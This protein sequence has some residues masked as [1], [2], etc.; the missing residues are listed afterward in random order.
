MQILAV[1]VRYNIPLDE[2]QTLSGLHE[3]FQ[4]SPSLFKDMG[5]LV[6]DNSPEA[7]IDPALPFPFEYRHSARNGGVSG[8]YNHALA[9]AQEKGARWMLLLDQDTSVTEPYLQ[10]MIAHSEHLAAQ[11]NIAAIVPVVRVGEFI[12]SPRQALFNL[13]RPYSGPSGV[14]GG[15]GF[16][17]NSGCLMRVEA[18]QGVG[19]FSAEFW[20]DYS[21]MY[22]FHQFFVRGLKIFRAADAELQ[23]QMTIMD[24][25]NLMAPWRYKNF[26]EAE[27]AFNDLYKSGLENAVQTLRLLVRAL[28][29]RM[30]YKNPYFS[31]MTIE[32]M[33]F[34]LT[35]RRSSRLRTWRETQ[36]RRSVER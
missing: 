35:K 23:H 7:L 29:Q 16:A 30:R 25:D 2:S 10:A 28:R 31:Q 36:R 6:Y 17:I 8:A 22:V 34:R 12:V 1:V 15:E 26:I 21:D 27:G 11:P 14:V 3:V 4:R 13:H 32:H 9:I 18:L 33:V 20:L 24:Y 19:G 5:I